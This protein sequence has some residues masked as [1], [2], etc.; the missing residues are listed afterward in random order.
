MPTKAT[1]VLCDAIVVASL[2]EVWS[3]KIT[4]SRDQDLSDTARGQLPPHTIYSDGQKQVIKPSILA[5]LE[6]QRRKAQRDLL[7]I[8]FKSPLGYIIAPQ[9]EADLYASMD[10]CRDGFNAARQDLVDNLDQ[11]Y[12]QWEL[13]NPGHEAFLR[14][15]RPTATDVAARCKFDFAVFRVAPVDSDQGLQQF[16]AVAKATVPSLVQDIA[17]NAK[18]ILKNSFKQRA[19]VTQRSMTA[20]REL[21]AK[22]QG[23]SMFDPRIHP[24]AK[25]LESIVNGVPSKG[26]LSHME[27]TIIASMLRTLSDPDEV[28]AIGGR[29]LKPEELT[30]DIDSDDIDHSHDAPIGI[31]QSS[32]SFDP[33]PPVEAA[34]PVPTEPQQPKQVESVLW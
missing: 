13:D 18:A 28:L 29:L 26:P 15:K 11:H 22:L 24:S 3:G 33:P 12:A 25:A 20:V 30:D 14:R 5:K 34:T 21:V 9:H 8:G 6:S 32:E 31:D 19:C 4:V 23:F 17:S 27:T 2:T 7:S 10:E 1:S 16:E